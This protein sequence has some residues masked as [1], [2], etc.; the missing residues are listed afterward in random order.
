[1]VD[2]AK[3]KLPTPVFGAPATK[4][5]TVKAPSGNGGKPQAGKGQ[6]GQPKPVAPDQ[7]KKNNGQQ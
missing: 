3:D 2:I 7:R 5:P 6:D 1:M 4:T